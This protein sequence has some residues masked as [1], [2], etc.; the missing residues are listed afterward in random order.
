[1]DMEQLAVKL[2]ETTDRSTRD[3]GIVVYNALSE[4]VGLYVEEMQG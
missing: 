4:L 2:Q 3:T 1:M